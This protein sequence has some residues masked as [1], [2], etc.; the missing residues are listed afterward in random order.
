[1]D[2]LPTVFDPGKTVVKEESKLI[3]EL[4]KKLGQAKVENEWLKKKSA[5]LLVQKFSYSH[6]Q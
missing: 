1:M 3:E 5:H 2:N 6:D 4:Y